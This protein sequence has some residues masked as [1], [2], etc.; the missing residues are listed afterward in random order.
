MKYKVTLN[1][2]VYEVEV[3]MSMAHIVSE[4]PAQD[5]PDMP[6]AVKAAP[7]APAAPVAAP[8][9]PAAPKAAASG[10][11]PM[12]SPLPGTILKVFVNVGDAVSEGQV[13]LTLEAMKMENEINA[14]KAGTVTQV[15]VSAGA[16]V[17][18]GEVLVTIA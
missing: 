15:L 5:L 7:V 10:G 16:S 12:P 6:A 17:Q 18:A 9:A 3:E 8:A 4:S 11:T 1:N 2:V 14:P 13:L